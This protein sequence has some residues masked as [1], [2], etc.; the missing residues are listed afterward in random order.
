MADESSWRQGESPIPGTTSEN[1][2]RLLMRMG[3]EPG[4]GLGPQGQGIVTP[5]VADEV[6]AGKAGL[7]HD[8]THR[9]TAAKPRRSGKRGRNRGRRSTANGGEEP[10]NDASTTAPSADS[11]ES[12]ASEEGELPAWQQDLVDDLRWQLKQMTAE[13]KVRGTMALLRKEAERLQDDALMA[14]NAILKAQI[15]LRLVRD[16]RRRLSLNAALVDLP[17]QYRALRFLAPEQ[18]SESLALLHPLL[19]HLLQ[20]DDVDFVMPQLLWIRDVLPPEDY[21]TLLSRT[22]LPLLRDERAIMAWQPAY[23]EAFVRTHLWPRL[24]APSDLLVASTQKSTPFSDIAQKSTLSLDIWQLNERLVRWFPLLSPGERQRLRPLSEHFQSISDIAVLRRIV[25]SWQAVDHTAYEEL[26]TTLLLPQYTTAL[27]EGC[28]ED[29]D[30]IGALLRSL[31][32]PRAM[33]LRVALASDL[34]R[35]WRHALHRAMLGISQDYYY[36]QEQGSAKGGRNHYEPVV[37]WYRRVRSIFDRDDCMEDVGVQRQ[38]GSLLDIMDA[39]HMRAPADMLPVDYFDLKYPV[40]TD[41][42]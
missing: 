41:I 3:Y 36:N 42:D 29:V 9:K 40:K 14:R 21:A 6:K 11:E 15:M 8:A 31:G 38:L 18:P 26:F 20:L 10:S 4:R 30:A 28:R 25:D 1:A 7:G 16:T 27:D 35:R 23:S 24:R 2:L 33:F 34:F 39:L 32:L 22:V 13:D 17:S 5:V 12:S 19:M 37:Q